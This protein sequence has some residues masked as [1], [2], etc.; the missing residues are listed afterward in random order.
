MKKFE[1]YLWHNSNV[2]PLKSSMYMYQ[3]PALQKP[4]ATHSLTK[5]S[6]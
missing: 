5:L 6:F 4:Q 3:G 2:C 1:Y